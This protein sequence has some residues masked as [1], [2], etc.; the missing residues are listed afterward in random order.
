MFKTSSAVF[1]GLLC[2]VF[3]GG[4]AA[5]QDATQPTIEV[6]A[7]G[8]VF[9]DAD[10]AHLDFMIKHTAQTAKEARDGNKK[11]ITKF[12]KA[13]RKAGIRKK[14]ITLK[15]V[16]L[17]VYK[18][19]DLRYMDGLA[20]KLPEHHETAVRLVR[21]QVRGIK[22][23]ELPKVW[24][25]VDAAMAAGADPVRDTR[26]YYSVT[27]AIPT[28]ITLDISDQHAAT[29]KAIKDG[30]SRAKEEASYSAGLAGLKLKGLKDAKLGHP[31][32][33]L[34]KRDISTGYNQRLSQDYSMLGK[35]KAS[36]AITATYEVSP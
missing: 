9:V 20:P 34:I 21:V 28:F 3:L 25:L 16:N 32:I 4:P 17:L 36:V 7:T 31:T 26:G 8:T 14:D 2:L 27:Q 22:A 6:T 10:M 11:A 30:F 13:M 5:A 24:K 1:A 18:P 29:R 35:I 15:P 19:Q 33:E 23:P 12:M